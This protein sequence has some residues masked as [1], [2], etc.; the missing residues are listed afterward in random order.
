MA[1][2]ISITFTVPDEYDGPGM[3]EYVKDVLGEVRTDMW[4]NPRESGTVYGYS[5]ESIGVWLAVNV[6][7][8]K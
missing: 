8:D 1:R 5:G 4:S 6:K 7:L 3:D 2:H